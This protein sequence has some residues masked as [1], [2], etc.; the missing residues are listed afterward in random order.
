MGCAV[1]ACE[2]CA[3][4]VSQVSAADAPVAFQSG[5]RMF[6]ASHHRAQRVALSCVEPSVSRLRLVLIQS[7]EDFGL[8]RKS[9]QIPRSIA[10]G[11]L[12]TSLALH[13][14][15]RALTDRSAPSSRSAAT[16]STRPAHVKTELS[17]NVP[18]SAAT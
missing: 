12:R 13:I 15:L 11:I 1:V 5:V 8:L 7:G 18:L 4:Y 9:G 6:R 16:T 14:T 3:A 17:C 2:V 10:I